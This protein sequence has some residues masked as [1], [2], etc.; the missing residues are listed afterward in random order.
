MQPIARKASLIV[1]ELPDEVLVY[2]QKTDKAHCLNATA[3][4]VW[5][6]ADGKT[7]VREIAR[8]LKTQLKTPADEEMVWLALDR[9]EKA[10]LLAEPLNRPAGMAL[11]SRREVGRR[12]GLVG[13]LAVGLPLVTSIVAPNAAQA[14]SCLAAGACCLTITPGSCCSGLCNQPSAG[15]GGAGHARCA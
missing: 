12:L 10:K 5:K 6:H 15:C 7:S 4:F 13:I 9:L 3:A 2:D 14:A 8:L 1:Q 11:V